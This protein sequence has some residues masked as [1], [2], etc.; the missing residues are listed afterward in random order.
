MCEN[1]LSCSLMIGFVLQITRFNEFNKATRVSD[2][3]DTS[4]HGL[5][6]YITNSQ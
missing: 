1:T 5:P 4:R 6:P 3:D 2:I